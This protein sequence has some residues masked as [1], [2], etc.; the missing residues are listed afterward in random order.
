MTQP[1]P[2]T[3]LPP[4]KY[5][6]ALVL[7]AKILAALSLLWAMVYGALFL[8]TLLNNSRDPRWEMLGPV[9]VMGLLGCAVQCF[10]VAGF[11]RRQP[12]SRWMVFA[13]AVLLAI[14]VGPASVAA[15][16]RPMSA[17]DAANVIFHLLVAASVHTPAVRHWLTRSPS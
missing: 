2:T 6:A 15:F 12:R 14:V 10:A 5:D 17:V 11:F 4:G 1:A 9:Y 16:G 3:D 8:F 13:A 7:A